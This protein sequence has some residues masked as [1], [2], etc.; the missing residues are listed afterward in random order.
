L[1]DPAE[2]K[3]LENFAKNMEVF[4]HEGK[5]EG[6]LV[7]EIC[8]DEEGREGYKT[9]CYYFVDH[10]SRV[11]FWPLEYDASH[12]IAEVMGITLSSDKSYLSKSQS[13]ILT[14]NQ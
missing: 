10:A 7:L 5:Y 11:I 4:Q 1:Y 8:D 6:D 14:F 2:Q 9:W 12:M 13:S 3:E